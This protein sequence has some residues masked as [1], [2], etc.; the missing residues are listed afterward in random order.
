LEQ[1]GLFV[2]VGKEAIRKAIIKGN[3]CGKKGTK[4]HFIKVKV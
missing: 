4:Y 2:G 1:A 3:K